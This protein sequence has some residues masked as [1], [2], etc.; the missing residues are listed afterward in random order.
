MEQRKTSPQLE[1]LQ[2]FEFLKTP[3]LAGI[4]STGEEIAL[5]PVVENL[6]L[7][8][9]GQL[10]V[11]KSHETY[12]QLWTSVKAISQDGKSREMVCLSPIIF[13]DWL[14]ALNPKSE[15][16][17]TE[18]WEQ[19]KKGLVI[20][21]MYMLK[22]SLDEIKRLRS[23]ERK[24]LQLKSTVNMM[25]SKDEQVYEASKLRRELNYE[26]KMIAKSLKDSLFGDIDQL[27]IED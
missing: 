2:N 27:T 4:C 8:W 22:M 6:G 11:I 7:D 19:Y 25:M 18:L 3:V 14:W 5:R 26:K 16:F 12:S 10:K 17:N 15:K 20:H 24:Y 13:Q 23:I 21:L 1:V 9:S